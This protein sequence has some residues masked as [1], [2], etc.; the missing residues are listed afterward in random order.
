MVLG[1]ALCLACDPPLQISGPR[2]TLN[3]DC[4]EHV[5]E[6][7]KKEHNFRETKHQVVAHMND[8]RG[9]GLT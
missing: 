7:R 2:Y 1:Q 8:S 5:S 4:H 3:P 6:T 9:T